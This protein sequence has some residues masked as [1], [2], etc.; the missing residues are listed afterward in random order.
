M[1]FNDLLGKEGIDPKTV[2]V[3]RHRP[4]QREFRKVLPWLA[5]ERPDIYNAYQQQQSLSVEPRN[6]EGRL[7]G[8]VHRS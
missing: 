6:G 8:L 3:L 2:L 4:K 7:R 5:A 1:E